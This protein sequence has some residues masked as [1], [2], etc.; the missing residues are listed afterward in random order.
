MQNST[1]SYRPGDNY[2]DDK[3]YDNNL[4]SVN[5]NDYLMSYLDG[6]DAGQR[7]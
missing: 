3:F 7:R 5:E 6:S 1:V 2:E 4:G